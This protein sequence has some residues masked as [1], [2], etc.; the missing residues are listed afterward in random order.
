MQS[1]W[2]CPGRSLSLSYHPAQTTQLC[3]HARS[4]AMHGD[5]SRPVRALVDLHPIGTGG[6]LRVLTLLRGL[7][8]SE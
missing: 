8:K 7:E 1:V 4:C 3:G 2:E 6:T 5:S